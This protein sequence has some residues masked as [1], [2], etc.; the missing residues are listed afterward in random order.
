MVKELEATLMEH[1]KYDLTPLLPSQIVYTWHS[2]W[3]DFTDK[4]SYKN[5]PVWHTKSGRDSMTKRVKADRNHPGS[6]NEGRRNSQADT[7]RSVSVKKSKQNKGVPL[8]SASR[9]SSISEK[10]NNQEYASSAMSNHLDMSQNLNNSQTNNKK[11]QESSR[12][13]NMTNIIESSLASRRNDM[14]SRMTHNTTTTQAGGGSQFPGC[15]VSFQLSNNRFREKGWTVIKPSLEDTL[16]D[17]NKRALL[18]LKTS[19]NNM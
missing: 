4:A 3:G 13:S 10:K 14:A 15:S 8:L 7:N 6:S 18:L 2:D 1:I 12:K 9:L 16:T 11:L 19:L 17:N 5:F